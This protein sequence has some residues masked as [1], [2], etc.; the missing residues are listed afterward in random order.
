MILILEHKDV[1]F[2][3]KHEL[4]LINN[5]IKINSTEYLPKHIKSNFYITKTKRLASNDNLSL[6]IKAT[7]SKLTKNNKKFTSIIKNIIHQQPI[8]NEHFTN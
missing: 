7:N 8:K 6:I 2:K 4:K 3:Y 1:Y 5:K